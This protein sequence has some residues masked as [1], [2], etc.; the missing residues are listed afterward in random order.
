MRLRSSITLAMAVSILAIALAATFAQ[1]TGQDRA[2]LRTVSSFN[3]IKDPRARSVAL[4]QEAGKVIQHPRCVN[5]HPASD[6]PTQTDL[7]WPHQPLVVR[8]PD[9]HGVPGM[10]CATCHHEN[11]FDP[12]RVPGHPEWHL[13]PASMAW[14]GKSLGEICEQIKDPKRNGNR[15]ISTLIHH[16]GDDSLVGWAWAPGLGRT[17]APGTQAMFGELM[18]AW[19]ASG[20]F[21]P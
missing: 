15:D 4:F 12:A 16:M 6:R 3:S 1:S 10:I 17:P 19:A 13:A 11:N 14:H 5:C 21:C 2:Q 20:A 9:G 18:N 8:G 7:M